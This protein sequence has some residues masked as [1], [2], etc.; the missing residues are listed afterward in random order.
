[1]RVGRQVAIEI[2]VAVS[3]QADVLVLHDRA[4]AS[5]TCPSRWI[6]DVQP[7]S[8]SG[9]YRGIRFSSSDMTVGT[10][11]I[12]TSRAAIY[13]FA[14][15]PLRRPPRARIAGPVG[16]PRAVVLRCDLR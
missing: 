14:R 15:S 12:R 4:A 16:P 1:M 13:R 7:E 8:P 9:S 11:T 6:S 10:A 2:A 5:P 3:L